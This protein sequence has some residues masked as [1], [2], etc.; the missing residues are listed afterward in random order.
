MLFCNDV[1]VFLDV[2]GNVLIVIIDID[3]GSIDDIIDL[4]NLIFEFLE[5]FF[6]CNDIGEM[7]VIFI[8]IDECGNE[9]FCNLI[10]IVEDNIDFDV[11]CMDYMVYFDVLGM[12]LVIVDDIDDGSN[13][14]CSIEFCFFDVMSFSCLD[15]GD[16]MVILMVEDFVGNIVM[17]MCMVMVEDMF[18]LVMFC[19]DLLVELDEMGIVLIDVLDV[20]IGIIDN[21]GILML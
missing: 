13:D 14:N 6:I 3:V 1:I 11:L 16:N 7:M 15:F 9:D 18:L 20:D 12:V 2:V 5:Y 4:V 19:I 10:V 8:V 17:C 21:C